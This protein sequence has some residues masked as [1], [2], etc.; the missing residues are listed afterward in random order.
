MVYS[1][2]VCSKDISR[3]Y[4]GD[5]SKVIFSIRD[6]FLHDDLDD[7]SFVIRQ[8]RGNVEYNHIMDVFTLPIGKTRLGYFYQ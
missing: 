6:T 1:K 2:Q 8:L 3:V 5:I 4:S 7:D